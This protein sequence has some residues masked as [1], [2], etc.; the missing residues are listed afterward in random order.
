MH[1]MV[2]GRPFEP[3]GRALGRLLALV[4]GVASWA[5]AT[6]PF[7]HAAAGLLYVRELVPA[8][9]LVLLGL[10]NA[11]VVVVGHR[12]GYEEVRADE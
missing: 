8:S 3:L 7:A 6:F 4:E 9:T 12:H 10:V 5:A 11:V 1:A 2:P